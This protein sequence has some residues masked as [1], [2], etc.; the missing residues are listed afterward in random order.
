MADDDDTTKALAE[1]ERLL[2]ET[3]ETFARSD[4]NTQ[5]L[6]DIGHTLH[7]LGYTLENIVTIRKFNEV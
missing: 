1:I 6:D 7:Y 3:A 4:K 2:R 5:D